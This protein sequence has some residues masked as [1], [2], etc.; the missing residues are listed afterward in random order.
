MRI[1]TRTVHGIILICTFIALATSVTVLTFPIWTVELANL[2]TPF[3]VVYIV[4][5]MPVIL[6]GTALSGVA[7]LILDIWQRNILAPLPLVILA[8]GLVAF[9]YLPVNEWFYRAEFNIL[10]G[11]RQ[12][13]VEEI[14]ASEL[15]PNVECCDSLIY[16]GN[17]RRILSRGH[18]EVLYD[19]REGETLVFFFTYHGILDNYEGYLYR[20]GPDRPESC[21]NGET[22]LTIVKMREH[23]YW[24][25]CT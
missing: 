24:M 21:F 23:W 25:S 10:Y 20:S 19:E 16:L 2:I 11:R 18:G 3:L 9:W 4:L 14:E 15:Q 6:V 13:V 8:L 12:T 17:G 1:D 22:A 5:V 7:S